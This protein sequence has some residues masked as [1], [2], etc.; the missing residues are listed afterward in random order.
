MVVASAVAGLNAFGGAYT[1]ASVALGLAHAIGPAV[2]TPDSGSG[3][4]HTLE[5][6]AV[7]RPSTI[8]HLHGAGKPWDRFRGR[9]RRS[10]SRLSPLLRTGRCGMP[11][12][13]MLRS[14]ICMRIGFGL[15][16]WN[17]GFAI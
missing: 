14:G 7:A 2:G 10:R 11:L 16:E 5:N 3:L 9:R 13:R 1:R 17:A 8:F 15:D 6:A 4:S 12:I